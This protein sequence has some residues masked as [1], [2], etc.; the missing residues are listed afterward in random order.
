VEDDFLERYSLEKLRGADLAYVEEHL[1]I[2]QDCR[3]R[4]ETFDIVACAYASTLGTRTMSHIFSN[5]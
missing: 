1:F 3:S 4:L 2:C 5:R